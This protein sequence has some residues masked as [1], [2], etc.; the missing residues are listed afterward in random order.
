MKTRKTPDWLQRYWDNLYTTEDAQRLF[1]LSKDKDASDITEADDSG[2]WEESSSPALTP[3]EQEKEQYRAEARRL[4]QQLQAPAPQP[5]RSKTR[6]VH[7][8][9]QVAAVVCFVL[10]SVYLWDYWRKATVDYL[11]VATAVNEHR[12]IMLPDG[13]R[14]TLNACSRVRYPEQFLAET[15]EV[16]LEGEGFFSVTHDAA[17]PFVVKT[18][19]MD[20]RVLGTRFNVKSYST[21]EIIAVEVEEGKVQIDL[22]EAMMRLKA[23]E[24]MVCNTSSDVFNKQRMEHE[25]ATWR[26]GFLY[27][28]RTPMSD[29]VKTLER[30]Y[31]CRIRLAPDQTFD[32]LISGEH[33]N[34]NLESVL[35]S[36]EFT[37]GI[38]YRKEGND[39]L[40]YKD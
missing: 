13:T 14:L 24:Q 15:R 7:R 2:L 40:L 3:D 9:L 16:E 39:I 5:E 30:L 33:D 34:P 21:D 25:A 27:F 8:L 26:K 31:G 17:H 38:H 12:D 4:L 36:I 28:D 6:F 10:G 19:R 22:P 35:Q 37:S 23:N 11:E 20:V 29:V 18:S 1:D 32:N